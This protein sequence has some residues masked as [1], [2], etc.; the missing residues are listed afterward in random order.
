MTDESC[1][2]LSQ[3]SIMAINCLTASILDVAHFIGRRP[4]SSIDM[5]DTKNK[6]K[7]KS[8]NIKRAHNKTTRGKRKLIKSNKTWAK[9]RRIKVDL[10]RTDL[11]PIVAIGVYWRV[12]IWWRSPFALVTLKDALDRDVCSRQ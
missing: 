5:N 8:S 4:F 1:A 11:R 3:I 6:R 9:L 2:P 7:K 12:A 10:E